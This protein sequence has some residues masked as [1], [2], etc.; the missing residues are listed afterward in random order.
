MV[1]PS[2]RLLAVFA[3]VIAARAQ[4]PDPII[5]AARAAAAAFNA[6]L[7]NYIV[8]RTTKRFR[9]DFGN[10]VWQLADTVTA[11]V[12]TENGVVSD[13][14]LRVDEFAVSDPGKTGWWSKGEFSNALQVVLSRESNAKFTKPRAATIGNRPAVRY[15]Y[16][17]EQRNSQWGLTVNLTGF[18]VAHRGSIWIDRA[19]SRVLRIEMAARN[20]PGAFRWERLLRPLNMR[21]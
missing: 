6:S 19:T 4:T 3:V 7:P 2:H 1:R 10:Q 11:D 15:D 12:V 21:L 13:M 14:N 5:E 17:V 8:K 9:N 18:S 20:L 16:E